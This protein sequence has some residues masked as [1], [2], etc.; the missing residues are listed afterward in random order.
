MNRRKEDER[1]RLYFWSGMPITE[2]KVGLGRVVEMPVANRV[3]SP[4]RQA[5]ENMTEAQ[6]RIAIL[7][8]YRFGKSA[9]VCAVCG[10]LILTREDTRYCPCCGEPLEKGEEP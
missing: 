4:V 6:R 2:A 10:R 5:I 3:R 8:E 1:E 9:Q 7:C